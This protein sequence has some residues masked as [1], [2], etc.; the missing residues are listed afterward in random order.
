MV[1]AVSVPTCDPVGSGARAYESEPAFVALDESGTLFMEQNA[2]SCRHCAAYWAGARVG[3]EQ[4]RGSRRVGIVCATNLTRR[5]GPPFYSGKTW[6]S[7][8][9]W[10]KRKEPESTPA[11]GKEAAGRIGSLHSAGRPLTSNSVRTGHPL[12][13]RRESKGHL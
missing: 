2:V 7:T 11:D 5:H 4:R 12:L 8:K 10:R 13:A 6:L 3:L 9:M 1:T